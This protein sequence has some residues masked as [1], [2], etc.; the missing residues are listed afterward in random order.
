MSAN[1]DFSGGD[2]GF[3]GLLVQSS[4]AMRKS[5]QKWPLETQSTL[6]QQPSPSG[7][8]C[9]RTS[10]G[11]LCHNGGSPWHYHGQQLGWLLSWL[12]RVTAPGWLPPMTLKTT[13]AQEKHTGQDGTTLIVM[14]ELSTTIKRDEHPL[15]VH[16]YQS[17]TNQQAAIPWEEGPSGGLHG[18]VHRFGMSTRG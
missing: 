5:L 4:S 6:C 7:N 18:T 3:G 16:R 2:V 12:V 10:G 14:Q 15:A 1:L 17:K 9:G 11:S 8:H 13:S